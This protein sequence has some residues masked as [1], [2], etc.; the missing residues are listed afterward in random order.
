METSIFNDRQPL[1]VV[2]RFQVTCAQTSFVIFD[3]AP[4]PVRRSFRRISETASP[5]H[6]Q[7]AGQQNYRI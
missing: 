7:H 6:A 4:L 3:V 1:R 2:Q 5:V